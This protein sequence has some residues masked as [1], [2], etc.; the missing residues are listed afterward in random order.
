M[1]AE[2]SR[3]P[4]KE[5]SAMNG[6][7]VVPNERLRRARSLKGWSQADL[8]AKVGTS[9]EMISR[10]E[11]GVTVPSPY[12]R[13]RLCAA[14]SKSPQQLGLQGEA[15]GSTHTAS[16]PHILLMSSHADADKP[17]VAHL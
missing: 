8:A 2:Q 17:V 13:E 3:L 15:S 4:E 9:F 12:Y 7:K 5:R 16:A 14:L 6:E 1:I 10:W 11:R